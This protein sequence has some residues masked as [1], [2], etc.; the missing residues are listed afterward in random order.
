[1]KAITRWFKIKVR[2]CLECGGE[3]EAARRCN[4]CAGSG[5]SFGIPDES[6]RRSGRYRRAA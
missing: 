1:M 3:R 5:V 2:P 4:A 6:E